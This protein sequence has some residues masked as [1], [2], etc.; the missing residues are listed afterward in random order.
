[1]TTGRINQIAVNV[2]K[3]ALLKHKPLNA[4]YSPVQQKLNKGS[5]PSGH[6]VRVVAHFDNPM[7]R[8]GC[9]S[10]ERIKPTN[11]LL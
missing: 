6:V 9:F 10:C 2:L 4:T 5:R 8:R 1:M 11:G 3:R 7:P